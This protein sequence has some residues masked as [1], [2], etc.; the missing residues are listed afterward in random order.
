MSV[1]DQIH[2]YEILC[3]DIVVE[4][5]DIFELFQANCLLEKLPP[6]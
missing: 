5:M 3:A 4:G 6:S 1:L 2:E